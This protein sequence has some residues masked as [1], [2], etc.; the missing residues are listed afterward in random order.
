MRNTSIDYATSGRADLVEL[1]VDEGFLRGSR[2]DSVAEHE[3]EDY[4]LDFIDLHW[5]EPDTEKL[6]RVAERHEPE[7]AVAGD[8]NRENYDVINETAEEIRQYADNVIVVPHTPGEVEFIPD[9]CLVGFSFPSDYNSTLARPEEYQ[10]RDIHILGGSPSKV[11]RFIR[12]Y[13]PPVS[14]D[15]NAHHRAALEFGTYWN[16]ETDSWR[17]YS[18]IDPTIDG[19]EK[20]ESAYVESCKNIIEA[21]EVAAHK[22]RVV[23]DAL[24]W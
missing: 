18:E 6:V 22:Y 16:P 19:N 21:I 9:W 10:G 8:Y 15:M 24:E 11:R 2:L 3:A 1:A 7:Y 20:A 17:D 14:L 5:E 13:G 4:S 23:G 12:D